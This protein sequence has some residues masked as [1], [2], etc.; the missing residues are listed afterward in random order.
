LNEEPVLFLRGH[1]PLLVRR[2]L[3]ALEE[4]LESA[5]YLSV[6]LRRRFDTGG[7]DFLIAV[8]PILGGFEALPSRDIDRE[9]DLVPFW[10]T[11]FVVKLF[12]F[13]EEFLNEFCQL[14]IAN[15][16]FV[17]II[18]RQHGSRRNRGNGLAFLNQFR[19]VLMCKVRRQI[20]LVEL[21]AIGTGKILLCQ[22]QE[23]HAI[24]SLQF[25]Q[26]GLRSAGQDDVRVELIGLQE[27]D[28]IVIVVK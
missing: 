24:G 11:R 6:V 26:R 28:G 19:I 16:A 20:A 25:A 22:C 14:A 8:Q 1:R 5:P 21:V 13:A 9:I 4:I 10:M 15:R 2:F 23:T 18:D 17:P 3:I 27:L 12:D 7:H